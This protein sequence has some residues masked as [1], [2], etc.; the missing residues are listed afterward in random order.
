MTSPHTSVRAVTV[1]TA[2]VFAAAVATTT[3]ACALSSGSGSSSETAQKSLYSTLDNTQDLLGGTWDNQDD[4]TPRG[5]VIPLWSD[6]E[7][8]PALRVGEAPTR[9]TVAVDAVSTYWTDLGL[10][11]VITNVGDVVEIQ[12]KSDLGEKLI[13][14]VSEEAMTLQG[15]SECRPEA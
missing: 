6:G 8:F 9:T 14:R 2:V 5:C 11:L 10:S 13:L 1:A 7:L 4:P 12:G 15:E 3:T